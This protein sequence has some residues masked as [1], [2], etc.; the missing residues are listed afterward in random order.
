MPSLWMKVIVWV[1]LELMGQ[2]ALQQYHALLLNHVQHRRQVPVK[3]ATIQVLLFNEAAER[4]LV[5]EL[6]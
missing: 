3:N 1:G 2:F 6:F 4:I 5:G